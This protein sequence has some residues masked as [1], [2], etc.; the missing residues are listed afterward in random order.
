MSGMGVLRRLFARQ[1]DREPPA[2]SRAAPRRVWSDTSTRFANHVLYEGRHD[3]EIV[4][5]SN[6]QDALWRAAGG[7]TT[8]RIRVE[9]RAILA[10]E[11]DNPHDPNAISVWVDQ[12]KVGYLWLPSVSTAGLGRRH[13]AP[14]LGRRQCRSS[15]GALHIDASGA[16][17]RCGSCRGRR[18]VQDGLV[19]G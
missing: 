6:Y 3:L 2:S 19:G 7:R 18:G 15:G 16:S 11:P 5:E 13:G 1:S 14:T 8:E 10:A 4:G 9:I 12:R 17:A